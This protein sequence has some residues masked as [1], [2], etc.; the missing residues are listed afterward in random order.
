MFNFETMKPTNRN[1]TFYDSHNIVKRWGINLYDDKELLPTLVKL[2]DDWKVKY[3]VI[4][5]FIKKNQLVGEL[6]KYSIYMSSHTKLV[7]E[8]GVYEEKKIW[9]NGRQIITE[10]YHNVYIKENEYISL[11]VPKIIEFII[12]TYYPKFAIY[13]KVKRFDNKIIIKPN[14]KIDD[15]CREYRSYNLT[16]NDIVNLLNNPTYATEHVNKLVYNIYGCGADVIYYP[17]PSIE[18]HGHKYNKSLV[19]PREAI[20]NNDWSVVE[21]YNLSSIIKPNANELL[22][23]DKNNWFSGKQKDNPYW[24]CK[25]MKMLKEIFEKVL[26]YVPFQ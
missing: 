15:I 7:A 22:G 24:N 23:R 25:E 11:I 3:N 6:F 9:K 17:L 14:M 8:K 2:A 18:V 20:V 4:V 21:N 12:A 26:N 16:A 10:T 1:V 19:I 13:Q 5:E